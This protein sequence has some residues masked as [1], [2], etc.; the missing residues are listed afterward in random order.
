M[1]RF[2]RRQR[3]AALVLAAV[4]VAFI[5]LDATAGSLR[6]AHD[7]VRGTLGALYRG[8]DSILG[9]VRRFV[10]AL[11]HAASYAARESELER[12]NR[13]LRARLQRAGTDAATVRAL[14]RLQLTAD[15][16]GSRVLPA[17]VV[18]FAPAQGFDWTLTLDAGSLDGARVGQTVTDGY[19]L[20]GRVLKA[21]RSTCTVLLAVD[22]ASGVGVRDLRNGEL[23]VATGTGSAGFT[24]RPLRPGVRLAVGDRLVTGPAGSST[25]VAGL[26]V[27][28]VRSVRLS[29]GTSTGAVTPAT[30]PTALDVVGLVLRAGD[31]AQDV[32]AAR[33]ALQPASRPARAGRAGR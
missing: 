25:Y 2:S 30:S 18:A 24:V 8:T 4:A 20:V 23:A 16:A 32:T 3:L 10:Q 13:E 33:P 28:T 26:A 19:G 31:R 1:R 21:D 7:G 27:G 11:P 9:P 6:S 14:R 22:P 29:G 5:A 17:R 15:A 12:R